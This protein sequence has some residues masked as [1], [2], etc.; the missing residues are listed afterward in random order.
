MVEVAGLTGTAD[1]DNDA[2]HGVSALC[3]HLVVLWDY[4]R[5]GREGASDGVV[6]GREVDGLTDEETIGLFVSVIGESD[7][8]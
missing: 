1:A 4:Q 3:V 7:N 5:I 6:G 2:I 8:G